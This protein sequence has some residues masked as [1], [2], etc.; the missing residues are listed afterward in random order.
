[1]EN[2][3]SISWKNLDKDILEAIENLGAKGFKEPTVRAVYYV[4]GSLG[5]IPL[6]EGGYKRLD[7]KIVEMRRSGRIPWGFFAVK[8]GTYPK[9]EETQEM[10]DIDLPTV[11]CQRCDHKW[12]P[13]IKNPLM[14]PKC[15]GCLICGKVHAYRS[16]AEKCLSRKEP[17]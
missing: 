15:N 14:C 13:R 5:K 4:L 7:A 12:T 6:T 3:R 2:K 1:M 11:I 16:V 10:T 17:V 8:R 9:D